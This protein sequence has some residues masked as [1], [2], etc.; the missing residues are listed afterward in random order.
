MK[1]NYYEL[2][3]NIIKI[4]EQLYK[5]GLLIAKDG[6]ISIRTGEDELLIT[7][8]GI[9]KGHLEPNQIT[10]IDFKGNII[11]GELDPARDFRMHVE[12]YKAR[13]NIKAIAHAHPPYISGLAMT[14]K[15]IK[16]ITLPEVLFDLGEI[17]T[18]DYATPTTLEV[19]ESVKEAL[20]RTENTYAVILANHGAVTFT[21]E[22]PIDAFYKMEKLEG[23]IQSTMIAQQLGGA[24]PL[25]EKQIEDLHK[26]L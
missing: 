17:E 13:P 21:E 12:I 15:K 23:L 11:D 2:K 26:L 10:K 1:K 18:A 5:K 6:N 8:T 4:G 3:K 9:C 20:R 22:E 25:T 19:P 14:R 16:E 7:G 24:V